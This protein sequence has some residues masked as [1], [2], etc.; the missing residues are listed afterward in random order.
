MT[1]DEMS[2][3]QGNKT[4]NMADDGQENFHW[5]SRKMHAGSD[6]FG[7]IF[8]FAHGEESLRAK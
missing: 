8:I 3:V 7:C 5:A 4:R 6:Q 1:D 2:S